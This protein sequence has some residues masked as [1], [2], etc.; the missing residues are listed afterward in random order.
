MRVEA[1]RPQRSPRGWDPSL[2]SPSGCRSRIRR[3]QL[4]D[5]SV[6]SGASLSN[7]VHRRTVLERIPHA[8]DLAPLDLFFGRLLADEAC[9]ARRRGRAAVWPPRRTQG[10]PLA[11]RR[12]PR[13]DPR[14]PSEPGSPPGR[15]IRSRSGSPVAH[16]SLPTGAGP[17]LLRWA[18][19]ASRTCDASSGPPLLTEP[20]P[21]R[22]GN[23][24][25][26][27]VFPAVD[28]LHHE[29]MDQ[30]RELRLLLTG[31]RQLMLGT[32]ASGNRRIRRGI[33]IGSSPS[34]VP[35]LDLLPDLDRPQLPPDDLLLGSRRRVLA[36]HFSWPLKRKRL[37]SDPASPHL[38]QAASSGSTS[39]WCSPGPTPV[40][41][42]APSAD[43]SGAS[44][45]AC[46]AR[47]ATRNCS[48]S[49]G[50]VSAPGRL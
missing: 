45:T 31:S 8:F 38:S 12:P 32:F 20:L 49:R 9:R 6:V 48:I 24:L 2:R 27:E 25:G 29:A 15:G 36:G 21:D 3:L 7:L 37:R 28:H 17:V 30:P 46:C 39:C 10:P 13:W 19:I 41:R 35:A 5:P 42:W 18:T 11:G 44:A 47:C 33:G 16:A 40:S 22:L 50:S 4:A 1:R 23:L 14:Q 34:R 43:G 26:T